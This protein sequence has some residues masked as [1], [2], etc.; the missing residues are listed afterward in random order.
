MRRTVIPELLDHDAGTP[1]EIEA[2]LADLRRVNRWF[3]GISTTTQLVRRAAQRSGKRSLSLLEVA[4]ASGDV[5]SETKARLARAGIEL[6]CVLLDRSRCHLRNGSPAVVGD[7]FALPFRDQSFD[8]VGC[9]LF[10]HH[11]EPDE[12]TRFVREALRVA[13]VGV[14]INDLRR[15]ALHLALIYSASPFFS[16]LTRH[17]APASVRRAYTAEEMH[18][19]LRST[20]KPVEISDTYLCRMGAIVWNA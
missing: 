6:S 4:A 13:R 1:A 8:L 19:L 3:G 9:S 5:P 15:S 2:S 20:G 12:I 14:L 16:R 18:K 7:A 17:D 11:L 10:A